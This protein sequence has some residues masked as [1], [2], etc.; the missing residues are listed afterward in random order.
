MSPPHRQSIALAFHRKIVCLHLPMG[1]G[2][3]STLGNNRVRL[4]AGG[5]TVMFDPNPPNFFTTW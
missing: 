1:E 5:D 4:T 3:A 2:M